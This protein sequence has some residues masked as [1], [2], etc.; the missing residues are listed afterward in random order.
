MI[1]GINLTLMARFQKQD[2]IH[3]VAKWAFFVKRRVYRRT[4]DKGTTLTKKTHTHFAGTIK[5]AQTR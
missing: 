3:F 4:I 5:S 1:S 2:Q